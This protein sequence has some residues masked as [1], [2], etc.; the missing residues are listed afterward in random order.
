MD[1]YVSKEAVIDLVMQYCPDDDGS[2]SK[3]D[4]DL[5]EMLDEL[6]ALHAANVKPAVYCK[7]IGVYAETDQF[8]CSNCG[9]ELRGWYEV[10]VETNMIGDGELVGCDYAFKFCPDCGAAINEEAL[11]IIAEQNKRGD[12]E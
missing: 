1:E 12:A 5:R 4:V 3:A 2:C 8:I 7:N 10:T 9:I 6:E 11:R